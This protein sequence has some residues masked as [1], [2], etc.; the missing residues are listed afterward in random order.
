MK[1]VLYPGGLISL[2]HYAYFTGQCFNIYYQCNLVHFARHL[3]ES[4]KFSTGHNE[5][6]LVLSGRQALFAKTA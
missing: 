4:K 5:N 6:L 3:P 2:Y 1:K